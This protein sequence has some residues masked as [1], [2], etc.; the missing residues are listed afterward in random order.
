MGW[1]RRRGSAV[2]GPC[3]RGTSGRRRPRAGRQF[4]G[5]SERRWAGRLPGGSMQGDGRLTQD[6]ARRSLVARDFGAPQSRVASSQRRAAR[7]PARNRRG[8]RTRRATSAVR[9]RQGS[10]RG[11]GIVRPGQ[12]VCEKPGSDEA[13]VLCSSDRGRHPGQ[14]HARAT[15]RKS[16]SGAAVRNPADPRHPRRDPRRGDRDG[17]G[18]RIRCDLARQDR[19]HHRRPGRRTARPRAAS[20]RGYCHQARSSRTLTR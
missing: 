12:Y 15:W 10:S 3:L 19:G 11:G 5:F 8:S 4:D 2:C 6:G 1:S 7:R 13:K 17:R 18:A 20:I 14:L 16:T 9:A